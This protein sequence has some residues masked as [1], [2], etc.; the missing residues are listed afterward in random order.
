VVSTADCGILYPPGDVKALAEALHALACDPARLARYKENA[1][2]AA[3]ERYN[4][5]VEEGRVLQLYARLL[6]QRVR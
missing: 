5:T 2:R 6:A 1:R 4:A 3:R